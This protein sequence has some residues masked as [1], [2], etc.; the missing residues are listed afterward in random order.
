MPKN[1]KFTIEDK[2]Y[3]DKR[4]QISEKYGKRELWSVIDH[5][6]LYCGI[7]NLGQYLAMH[8]IFCSVMNVPGHIAEFGS[9]RGASLMFWAKLLRIY[10]PHCNKMIH[11]F[12][13]FEGLVRFDK[14]DGDAA[15]L[16]DGQYKGSLEELQDM[17]VLYTMEDDVVIHKGFVEDTLA[18]TLQ[19][20]QELSFSFVYCDVDLYE[21]TK[22]ILELMHPRLSKGGVLVLD[23]WNYENFPGETIAVREF[24]DTYGHLYEQEHV[25]NS[26]QPSLVLR[27]KAIK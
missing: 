4:R 27:K 5:W 24:L 21:P 8:T 10:D 6:P 13:S 2:A 18:P 26:R 9:W 7:A 12:D 19:Q 1:K 15:A 11:C 14:Q 23:E 3:K 25:K 20:N 17:I 16:Y 22:V